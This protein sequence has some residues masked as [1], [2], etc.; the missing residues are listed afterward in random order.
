[1]SRT[2]LRA[3]E[4]RHVVRESPPGG[5]GRPFHEDVGVKPVFLW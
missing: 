1:M 4:A 2:C 3:P 5:P